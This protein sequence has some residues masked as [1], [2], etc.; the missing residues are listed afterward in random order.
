M[1][2]LLGEKVIFWFTDD[3]QMEK[4]LLL[5]D[6]WGDTFRSKQKGTNETCKQ[7]PQKSTNDHNKKATPL[8]GCK[9]HQELTYQSGM[10]KTQHCNVYPAVPG[11]SV[12]PSPQIPST[13]QTRRAERLRHKMCHELNSTKPHPS[14]NGMNCT[15]TTC[16]EGAPA[17]AQ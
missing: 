10:L 17:V 16:C 14:G 3:N 2:A 15:P 6:E 11:V 5:C 8:R 7:T 1:N 9:R 4:Q 13:V 12:S